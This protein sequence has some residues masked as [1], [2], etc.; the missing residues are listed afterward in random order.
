MEKAQSASMAPL[1][2]V[3]E[4]HLLILLDLV[5]HV[6]VLCGRA[7]IKTNWVLRWLV[8]LLL[9]LSLLNGLCCWC[10]GRILLK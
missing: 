2:A 5:E 8:L 9:R 7:L 4:P 10:I 6:T 3:L 1:S